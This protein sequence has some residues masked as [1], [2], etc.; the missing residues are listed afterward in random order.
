MHKLIVGL[1]AVTLTAG[2][3]EATLAAAA[4]NTLTVPTKAKAHAAIQWT[5]SVPVGA[6]PTADTCSGGSVLPPEEHKFTVKVPAGAYKKVDA[7]M[8][9]IVDSSPFLNGDFIELLSPSGQSVGSDQQKPEMQVNVADPAPG[10]WTAVVCQFLPD[11]HSAGHAYQGTV[12]VTTQKH[13]G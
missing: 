8:S 10:T 11:D 2:V 3:T 1:V 12:V 5:G 6:D 7:T 13:K 9:L 4:G